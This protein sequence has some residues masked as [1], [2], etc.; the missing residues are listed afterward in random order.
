MFDARN[1]LFYQR[2]ISLVILPRTF[3]TTLNSAFGIN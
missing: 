3:C 1:V 2:D